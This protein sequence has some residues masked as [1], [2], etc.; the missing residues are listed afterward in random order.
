MTI[1]IA[2]SPMDTGICSRPQH[3]FVQCLCQPKGSANTTR[4][5]RRQARQIPRS[6]SYRWPLRTEYS[7]HATPNGHTAFAKSP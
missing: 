2:T 1:T 5:E 4:P 6:T 7:V 3:H